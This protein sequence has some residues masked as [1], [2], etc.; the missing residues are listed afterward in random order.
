MVAASGKVYPGYPAYPTYPNYA[1]Y[2][3]VYVAKALVFFREVDDK[4]Q[5]HGIGWELAGNRRVTFGGGYYC[6]GS[7]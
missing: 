7:A 6:I 4:R 5:P 3:S 2:G 1:A